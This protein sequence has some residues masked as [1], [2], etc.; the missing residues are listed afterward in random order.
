[1]YMQFHISYRISD[2]ITNELVGVVEVEFAMLIRAARTVV[3]IAGTHPLQC[4]DGSRAARVVR[5]TIEA[6]P[7]ARYEV[8]HN[9]SII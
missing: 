3:G 1:M 8:V 4:K 9:D 6:V 2:E 7:L 5:P